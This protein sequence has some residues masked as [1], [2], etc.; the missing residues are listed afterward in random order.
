MSVLYLTCIGI[1]YM[2]SPILDPSLGKG[3]SVLIK[4]VVVLER[5]RIYSY[6][7]LSAKQILFEKGSWISS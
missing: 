2:V 6:D 7:K 5:E 3:D 1:Q 4:W